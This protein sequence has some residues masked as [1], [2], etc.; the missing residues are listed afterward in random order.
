MTITNFTG[1]GNQKTVEQQFCSAELTGGIH[2][3]LICISVLNIFLSITA[4]LGNTLI[5]VA[6]HKVTSLHPP[7]K[8]LYRSLATTD[9]FVGIILEPV[10]VTYWM[11]VVKERWNICRFA[12]GAGY[13]TGNIL[14]FVSLLTV[15]SIS[16]DRLLVLLLGLRFRQFLTLKRT[17]L[18]V[19]SLWVGSSIGSTTYFWSNRVTCYNY[20]VTSVCIITAVGSYIKIFFTLR[21]HQTRVYV[22]DHVGQV[23]PSQTPSPLNIARYRKA[24]STAFWVKLTLVVC[25]LPYGLLTAIWL[26]TELSSS[27]FLALAFAA[28]LLYLNS[29][30]NPVLY[31]W[32]IGEVRQ[33]VKNTIRQLCCSSR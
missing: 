28:T 1:D 3:Q 18:V 2:K 9:L 26:N 25:H 7:S 16:V 4:F 32:N 8:V 10:A 15:T 24:V 13:I 27:V 19:A 14:C 12:L 22:Q 6:L 31:C 17:Y 29:S 5:L 21:H 23:Q 20:I 33:A 30:L 11:S